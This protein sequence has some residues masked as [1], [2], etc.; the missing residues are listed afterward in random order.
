MGRRLWWLGRAAALAAVAVIAASCATSPRTANTTRLH[1]QA[2]AVLSRWSAA[3]AK[4]ASPAPV[5]L[6]GDLTGQIG[7]WEEAVGSNKAAL[8]AGQI[9]AAVGLPAETPPDGQVRWPDGRTEAVPL[10][11]AAAAL[12]A[13][14]TESMGSYC[15]E[16]APLRITAARLT[17]GSVETS[18]GP[19]EAP[20]WEFTIEGT[21]VRVTRV[22]IA[23]GVA[24][25]PP[26]SEPLD[27]GIGIHLDSAS[28]APEAR[29][30]TVYFTGA[31]GPAAE[32]CGAD[33]TAEAIESPNAV[34]VIVFE[35]PH[36]GFVQACSA[37][38]AERTATARLAAPLGD[39]TV[40]QV[41]TG[42][43][44]EFRPAP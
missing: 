24:A 9:Q 13:I 12:S 18:R 29:Q 37:V 35:H 7:D 36:V 8:M 34:V 39:R 26:G 6:V 31:P 4:A 42:E 21:A 1:E 43:P 2:E 27:A 5:V 15:P 17:S 44:V 22:A 32:P 41:T 10:M 11:S 20:L 23:G 33:Y 19:A 40:L 28:G 30:V 38:G 14:Q 16:C 25:V 3:L